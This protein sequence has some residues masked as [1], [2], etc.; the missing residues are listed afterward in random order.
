MNR[1]RNQSGFKNIHVIFNPLSGQKD[2]PIGLIKETLQSISGRF[3]IN[4]TSQDI[5]AK[6]LA[7]NAVNAGADLIIGYGGDG[8]VLE[9]AESL[10]D[11][12]VPLCV[13]PGG[14]ANVFARELGIPIAPQDALDIIFKDNHRLR[15]VDVGCVEGRCF[16]LRMGIGLEAAMTVRADDDLKKQYGVLAYLWSAILHARRMKRVKYKL[17]IDGVEKQIK[18]VTCV[19]CNSGNL[20]LPGIQIVPEIDVSDGCLNV[21]VIKYSHIKTVFSILYSALSGLVVDHSGEQERKAYALYSWEAERVT[22]EATPSQVI[23]VDGEELKADFPIS[24]NVLH[25]ALKVLVPKNK[26]IIVRA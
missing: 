5:S 7:E 8:T 21:V 22:V 16:L 14:T 10:I 12:D 11:K 25:K 24:V 13:I 6:E 1:V 23:A 3:K 15:D 4:K 26:G 17:N 20:G 19:I 2:P 9:I 18:G